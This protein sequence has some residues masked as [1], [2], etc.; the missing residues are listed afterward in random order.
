M[1]SLPCFHNSGNAQCG[2]TVSDVCVCVCEHFLAY[3]DFCHYFLH[4]LKFDMVFFS[5]MT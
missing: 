2:D 1:S 5:L 4:I 3:L